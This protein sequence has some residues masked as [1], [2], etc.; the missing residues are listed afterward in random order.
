MYPYRDGSIQAIVPDMHHMFN[1]A[2]LENVAVEI[3]SHTHALQN[4]WN[5]RAVT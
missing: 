3:Y 2:A 5:K 1:F 4:K